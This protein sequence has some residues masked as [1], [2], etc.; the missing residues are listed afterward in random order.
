MIEEDADASNAVVL[1]TLSVYSEYACAFFDSGATHSF[2]SSAFIRKHALSVFAIEYD[3]Y[4]ATQLGVDIVPD[5]ACVNCP[6]VIAG[7]ELLA[8]LHVMS[9][10]DYDINL[11]TD[12][13]SSSRAV[14]DCYAKIEKI[15]FKIP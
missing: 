6:I 8:Y 12:L 13:L 14:V 3:L 15:D 10:K 11:G 7:H 5:R 4:V 1:G 2:I 9:M